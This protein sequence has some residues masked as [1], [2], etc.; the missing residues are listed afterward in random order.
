MKASKKTMVN[1]KTKERGQPG[2]NMGFKSK[3]TSQQR[4]C[5]DKYQV[6]SHN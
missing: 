5:Q 6:N 1:N 2:G 4:K 3:W